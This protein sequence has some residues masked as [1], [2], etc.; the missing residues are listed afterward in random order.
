MRP[1]RT[2]LTCLAALAAITAFTVPGTATAAAPTSRH[3]HGHAG[4][5]RLLVS[6][7]E[8]TIGSTVG[9]DGALYVPE[10]LTG[11]VTRIDPRTGATSTFVSGLPTRVNPD[12][13]GAMDVA[14]VHHTAY[15][16]VTL[17]GSD[18]GGT[19]TVGVYRVDGPHQVTVVADI[20]SWAIA[21]PPVP[22]FFVPSGVQF[23]MQPYR[24][25]LLVTDG[26]HNRVLRID[27]DGTVGS[28]VSEVIAF[29]DIVPTGLAL[30]GRTVYLAEAGP[31][32]HLPATGKVVRFTT[33]HPVAQD[34]ASG[35]RLNVDVEFGPGHRL[36]ALSQGFFT[37]GHDEGSPANPDTGA[38]L[39]VNED[40]TMT[41]VVEGLDRPTS[42]EF[43]GRTAYVVNLAGEVWKIR[44]GHGHHGH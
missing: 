6:G 9:P 13:G 14:F 29:G 5:P 25:D 19:S 34:V 22:A 16:L 10:G 27:L 3:H 26:H 15:V 11:T 33:R 32:P 30:H 23:A 38:L 43:I 20:G 24:G 31:V 12:L 2:I 21:H 35:A 8:G 7:L 39:R 41:P 18:V 4:Q 40:G 36:Y 37:P 28:N 17:V 42:L 44:L 1:L